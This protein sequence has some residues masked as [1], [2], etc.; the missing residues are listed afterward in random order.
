METGHYSRSCTESP[1][2]LYMNSQSNMMAR[3]DEQRFGA[4]WGRHL[5]LAMALL[6]CALGEP[7]L[8]AD[9]PLEEL[10]EFFFG[11]GDVAQPAIMEFAPAVVEFD[12]EA[13]GMY[14]PLL[15]KASAREL[16]FAKKVCQPSDEVY[17]ELKTAA[18]RAARD[19]ALEYA[20][21]QHANQSTEEWPPPREY[22][23]EALLTAFEARMPEAAETYR[24]ELEA[25]H[26]ANQA[27]CQAMMTRAIDNRI[28]LLPDQYEPLREIVGK[29]WDQRQSVNLMIFLYDEYLQLPQLEQLSP[30][31]NDRQEKLLSAGNNHGRIHFGWEQDLG[32]QSWNDGGQEAPGLEDLSVVPVEPPPTKQ[33]GAPADEPAGADADAG[34]P[35]EI[36]A[37]PAEQ[38][39]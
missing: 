18:A 13:G 39:R 15:F 7:S 29:H 28:T 21:A 23:A 30:V 12:P 27:A 24:R 20:K 2:E 37:V 31:L 32:L 11:G 25:R 26:T 10:V 16:H 36:R 17:A 34:V 8:A 1:N 33:D 38:I 22:L 3:K 9:S 6:C 14:L 35:G 4:R 19:L 5:P